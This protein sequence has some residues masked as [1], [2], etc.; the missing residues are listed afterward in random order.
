MKLLITLYLS[1]FK[2]GL[3]GF[4][5]GYAMISLIQNELLTHGWLSLKDFVDIIAIAEM[6]PGPIAVNSGTFVGFKISSL[7]GAILATM[8]V[9]T[10]SLILVLILAHFFNKVKNSPHTTTILTFL[11][12]TVIGLIFA[13]GLSIGKFSMIDWKSYLIGGAV[14]LVMVKTKIHPILV[15]FLSGVVG[16]IIY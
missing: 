6:T 10:P 7:S 13:A 11:R 15:I 3:F 16:V 1:F 4:G 9:I 5:G 12:P 8:G 2:I 14:F